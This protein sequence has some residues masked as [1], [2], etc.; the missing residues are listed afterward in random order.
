M[1]VLFK[2]SVFIMLLLGITTASAQKPFEEGTIVYE[3]TI[4]PSDGSSIYSGTY[5]YIVKGK[6]IRKEIN[7][8]SGYTDVL[9]LNTS[10]NSFYSLKE[11]GGKK[12]AIQLDMDDMTKK[13]QQCQGFA[14]QDVSGS[15]QIAGMEAHKAIIRYSNGQNTEMYYTQEWLPVSDYM[16]DYFPGIKVL[17]L[18][19]SYKTEKGTV[20]FFEAQK[21]A[22]EPVENAA[23]RI[24]ADYKIISHREYEQM[25]N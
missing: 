14:F 13:I 17:P 24:P 3:L 19:Y 23:F 25:K 15:K 12:Y 18:Q 1:H 5:T 16:Y 21:V 22:A 8:N 4:Q 6:Q 2:I 11:Q 20:M 10:T 9:L 7:L